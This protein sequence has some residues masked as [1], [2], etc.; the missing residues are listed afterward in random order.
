M[1]TECLLITEREDALSLHQG[2]ASHTWTEIWPVQQG[3]AELQSLYGQAG[4]TQVDLSIDLCKP[5]CL[6]FAKQ[7]VSL[8]IADNIVH[9]SLT[10]GQR[11]QNTILPQ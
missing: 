2:K 9:C 1:I 10:S 11:C 8:A 5:A 7:T 3:P 4:Y 6:V